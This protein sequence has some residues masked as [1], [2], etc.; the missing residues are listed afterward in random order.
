MTT[1]AID[2]MHCHAYLLVYTGTG[3]PQQAMLFSDVAR[4]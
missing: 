3:G 1:A 4:L 2:L